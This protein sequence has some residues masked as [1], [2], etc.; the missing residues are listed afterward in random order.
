MEVAHGGPNVTVPEQA[1]DGMNVY[2]RLQEMSGKGV[3]QAMN[4]EVLAQSG[5]QPRTNAVPV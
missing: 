4:P 3:T 5:W 1:L 2:S